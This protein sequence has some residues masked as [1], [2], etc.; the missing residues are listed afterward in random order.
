MSTTLSENATH[1]VKKLKDISNI[2]Y[3]RILIPIDG[4]PTS[5]KALTAA[6]RLARDTIARVRF[7]H[8]L[9]ELAYLS[10]HGIYTAHSVELVATARKAGKKLLN[11]ALAI[12]ESAGVEADEVLLEEYGVRLGE[13]IAN[14]A[15]HW[16]ADLI[17]VGTHGR[18]GVGR[19]LLGSGAEQ[20]IRL[21][22]VN[23]LVVRAEASEDHKSTN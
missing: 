5:N 11:D 18:R 8:V 21:A 10:D 16:N 19:M 4:S 23:V 22:P 1:H 3:K 9:D 6:L 20:I 13:T 17:V 14:A 15:K 7:I 12:A 2:M